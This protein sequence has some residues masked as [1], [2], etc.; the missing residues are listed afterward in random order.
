MIEIVSGKL[1]NK[2]TPEKALISSKQKYDN[3][4]VRNIV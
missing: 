2:E 4:M 3:F 1:E